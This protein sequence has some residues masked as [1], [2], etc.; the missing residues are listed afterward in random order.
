MGYVQTKAEGGE[1]GSAEAQRSIVLP[2]ARERRRLG[3]R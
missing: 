3:D 2:N 1:T